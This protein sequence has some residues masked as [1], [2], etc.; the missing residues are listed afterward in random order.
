[1]DAVKLVHAMEK[2]HMHKCTMEA[3]LAGTPV[4]CTMRQRASCS[5]N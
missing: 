5:L 4:F 1:M 2:F 3:E